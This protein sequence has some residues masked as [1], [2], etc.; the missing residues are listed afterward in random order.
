MSLAGLS[1]VTPV[2]QGKAV[3]G[4]SNIDALRGKR[5]LQDS[6]SS[7]SL[8]KACRKGAYSIQTV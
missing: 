6:Q 4:Y 7:S 1:G 2:E 8:P 5:A 3:R